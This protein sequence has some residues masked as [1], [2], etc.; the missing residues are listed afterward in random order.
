MQKNKVKVLNVLASN[1]FS[2]AENVVCQMKTMLE[3]ECDMVYSSPNGEIEKQLL[4]KNISYLP[5]KKLSVKEVKRAIKEF[6]PDVIHAH[7]IKASVIAV[8]AAKKIPVIAHI[9]GSDAPT[10]SRFTPKSILFY[11]ASKKL[12]HIF[13]VSKS[14]LEIF[15]FKN[16]VEKKSSVLYN[17]ISLEQLNKKS[18]ENT[19]VKSYDI[20]YLGRLEPVKNPLRMLNI[21][22]LTVE[23]NSSTTAV[24]MGDGSM[25][26]ECKQFVK[27]NNLEDNIEMLGFVENPQSVLKNCKSLLLSSI[28]E[29]TPMCVLESLGLGVPVVSTP[30]DGMVDLIRNG[31][32]GYLYSKDDE[33]VKHIL[34]ITSGAEN[35][36]EQC[37]LFSKQYNDIQSYKNEI[38]TIYK[39]YINS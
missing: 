26:E 2:G 28:S 7:D 10:M 25:M 1:K 20:A 29:G 35:L 37:I 21:I 24:V 18:E 3:D 39:K 33:A 14:C 32:N 13:W 12:K 11:L 16:R 31:E 6:Q 27:D 36:Q 9:H 19:S 22:K 38:L 8:L 5:L 17:I 15:K 4:D 23:K 30:T 34:S